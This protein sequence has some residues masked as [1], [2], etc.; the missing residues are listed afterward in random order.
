[1]WERM[2]AGDRYLADDAEIVAAQARAHR[3][4]HA[5][6]SAPPTDPDR[7]N[8]LRELLGALGEGS[9]V[10]A[11]FSCDYG[12]HTF[13]GARTFV[14]FGLVCLDV[15]DVVI[16]DDV[17]I[18]PNVLL[19]TAEHPLE[20]EARRAK[21]ESARPI[22]IGDNAWLGAGVIVLPG[23]S[24]G[25]N[26]VVGAGSVVTR[27]VPAGVVAMGNPARVVREVEG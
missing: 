17:Q 19:V 8:V 12:S 24:V 10:R 3:L 27:D 26:T 22:A 2:R 25:A 15:A 9:E 13:I 23:V 20:A 7:L 11:P 1:M 18:G 21:W 4:M 16:G 6:N 14:N 5:F